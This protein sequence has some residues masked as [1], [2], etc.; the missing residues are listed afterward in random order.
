VA[1][2]PLVLGDLA[3]GAFRH[4]TADEVT[5]LTRIVAAPV[6]PEGGRGRGVV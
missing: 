4:L 6:Q 2:G 5:A 1:F 3:K